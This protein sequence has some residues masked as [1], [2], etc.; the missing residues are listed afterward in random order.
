MTA[1]SRRH[2]QLGKIAGV[3]R[4][5]TISNMN[6]LSERAR[7]QKTRRLA[8]LNSV[9]TSA[10]GIAIVYCVV[11][12]L[13]FLKSDTSSFLMYRAGQ[14]GLVSQQYAA[15]H[16]TD[17]VYFRQISANEWEYRVPRPIIAYAA[18]PGF[19]SHK[20][21]RNL[22]A[23]CDTRDPNGNYGCKP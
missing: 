14:L 23:L 15:D 21:D 18:V 20:T 2:V 4:Y 3:N 5:P 10:V 22:L 13:L 1:P 17:I 7:P 8:R 9:I 11:T 12:N 6:T 16:L 19:I